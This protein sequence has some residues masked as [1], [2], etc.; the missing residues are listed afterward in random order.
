[1][2][3]NRMSAAKYLTVRKS[4]FFMFIGLVVFV[5]YLYFF[6]GF[7]KIVLVLQRVNPVQYIF[8]YSMAIASVVIG[9]FFWVA[10]WRSALKTLSVKISM[11]NAFLYYWTGYFV[12]LA[13]PCETICGE[14][15]RL[16]L[17][18]KET[19]DSLGSIAA[20]GITNRIVS[21]IIVVTG[22]YTSAIILFLKSSIPTFIFS[23]LILIL[24]GASVYLLILLYLAFS[25]QAASK[26]TSLVL[27]LRRIIRPKKYKS[28]NA[29]TETK[30]NLA[31][32]YNGFKIFREK[33]K[34]LIKPFFFMTLSF[35]IN[36][37]SYILV[38]FA[39]GMQS[40]PFSF[41][42]IIYFIA[43]SIT[44]AAASFSV[45]TLDILLA[46]IFI[47]YGINPALSGITAGLVRSVTFWFPL[48][49]GYIIVQIVG[50]KKLLASK[51]L[52]NINQINNPKRVDIN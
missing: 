46:S 11:K 52:K 48:I 19:K 7:N 37:L 16:Y 5:I 43:G 25:K 27:R 45:G 24:F 15:T 42:I 28:I 9:N 4:F 21:Y 22:L 12:D 34:N 1:M 6:V 41:F 23:F 36:L 40:Q 31:S 14:V 17:V 8:F 51:P 2:V 26:V 35:L 18:Q 49:L 3:V 33:P 10:S 38:F 13:V 44:D 29:S 30:E 32:F 50:A 39:L 20:G 47:L